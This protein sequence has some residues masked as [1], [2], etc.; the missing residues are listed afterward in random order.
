ME[1]MSQE[2]DLGLQQDEE[3]R[4]TMRKRLK[5]S[6]I[7]EFDLKEHLKVSRG[8]DGTE[9]TLEYEVRIDLFANLGLIAAFENKVPLR[10]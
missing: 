1:K 4:E 9:L 6:G 8:R 2:N 10:E 3:I 5:L 7:R